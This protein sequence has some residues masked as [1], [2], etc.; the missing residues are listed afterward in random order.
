MSHEHDHSDKSISECIS[1]SVDSMIRVHPRNL[2]KKYISRGITIVP[3][4]EED[5][6][7]LIHKSC[8]IYTAHIS[9]LLS[10]KYPSNII[11]EEEKLDYFLNGVTE[12]IKL[13]T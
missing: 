1:V 10:Y 3:F 5:I 8:I 7:V 2:L 12:T 4:R 6:F 11:T 13:L 9:C